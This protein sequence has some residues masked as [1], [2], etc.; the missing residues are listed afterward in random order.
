MIAQSIAVRRQPTSGLSLE[1]S[2]WKEMR[3]GLIAD[4]H[5]TSGEDFIGHRLAEA[6]DDVP[7]V[8]VEEG[9]GYRP[10]SPSVPVLPAPP[11]SPAR[12]SPVEIHSRASIEPARCGNSS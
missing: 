6:P 2:A 1:L 3:N 12:P 4:E 9:D 10:L 7:M 5:K 11:P 8:T